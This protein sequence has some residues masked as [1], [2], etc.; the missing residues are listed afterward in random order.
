MAEQNHE[1]VINVREQ[2][3]Q[4]ARRNI[5]ELNDSANRA[6]RGGISGL[7]NA[8]SEL[9]DRMG[10]LPGPL[11]SAASGIS[12]MI[13]QV[14]SLTSGV[15]GGTI[16][17]GGLALGLAAAGVAAVVMGEQIA[18]AAD[19]AAEM[20][21]K[22]GVTIERLEALKVIAEDNSGS[23]EG[24]A[25]TL[26]KVAKSMTKIDEDSPKAAK[27]MASLGLSFEEMQRL[28]P[29]QQLAAIVN[30]YENL[31][32]SQEALA[33]AT[34]LAGGGFRDLIPMV[35][36]L[37]ED[38]GAATAQSIEFGNVIGIDL[39]EMGAR[40]E[41]ANRKVSDAW[42]GLTKEFSK[43][44][45]DPWIQFKSGAADALN[46]IRTVLAAWRASNAEMNGKAQRGVDGGKGGTIGLIGGFAEGVRSTLYGAK[47]P[48]P[49][50]TIKINRNSTPSGKSWDEINQEK[51]AAKEKKKLAD[52]GE[53]EIKKR[54]SASAGESASRR[55]A[56]A[57]DSA[58]NKAES[59][60]LRKA[61][62]SERT[63]A[64]EIA[65]QAREQI[66]LDKERTQEIER[67]V[68]AMKRIGEQGVG[69]IAG[70]A[71]AMASQVSFQRR[72]V[73]MG[74]IDRDSLSGTDKIGA[75]ADRSRAELNSNFNDGDRF[76]FSRIVEY[77]KQLASIN[78]AERMATAVMGEET[79]KRK[80]FQADWTNG[81][82]NAIATYVESANDMA[83]QI[84]QLGDKMF[85]GMEDALVS[86]V[87]T[88]K[89]SF[90][91]F[92]RSV[93]ADLVRIIAKKAIANLAESAAGMFGFANG[94]AFS[95]GTQF[96][97]NGG[98]VNR[99]TGFGMS[100]GK[101]GVMGEAGPE[102][103]MPL[104]RGSDG[105]LGVAMSGGGG[106]GGN[107]FSQVNNITIQ[108]SGD[109]DSDKQQAD[110]VAA[111]ID[112]KFAENMARANR[113]GGM[114]NRA[115]LQL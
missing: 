115:S 105:K 98:V 81:A 71:S 11:G 97:A 42:G 63:I 50:P 37:E 64:R 99:A 110:M 92:A 104:K 114:N 72:S 61:K 75:D 12:G 23:A 93:I 39:V 20:A 96:F 51:L 32:R 82:S 74:A 14:S 25:K 16:A 88:G 78:D 68:E 18:L 80:A 33:G 55:A 2:G 22:M 15:G 56:S 4:G 6:S 94:G 58:A 73:G 84:S 112:K 40:A 57:R 9:A 41:K 29:D 100:G 5:D 43:G 60:A 7:S 52:A 28:N 1:I 95:G 8:T 65:D 90:A 89:A 106:G 17:L 36:A 102:A 31:G 3:S 107:N 27:A 76:D 10:N 103:I 30:A 59:E 86:F 24:Y 38:A 85:K 53:A 19:D 113:P 26:E 21:D 35:K 108:S 45:A 46:W 77:N 66:R 87:T 69:R 83:G 111:A 54:K 13:S 62:E 70:T 48:E 34:M 49:A 101:M 109:G 67:Q 79:E 44:S 47:P 91:D